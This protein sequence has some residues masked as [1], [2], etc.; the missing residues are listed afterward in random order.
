MVCQILP[1]GRQRDGWKY[2]FAAKYASISY[3][4]PAGTCVFIAELRPAT[5]MALDQCTIECTGYRGL[6][7]LALFGAIINTDQM[8]VLPGTVP[9]SKSETWL[10]LYLAVGEVMEVLNNTTMLRL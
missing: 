7:G 4:L 5:S 9:I 3:Y 1:L 8:A 6:A 10:P 2:P